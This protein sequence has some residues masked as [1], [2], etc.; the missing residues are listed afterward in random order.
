MGRGGQIGGVGLHDDALQG[1]GLGQHL[2]EGR[3][4]KRHNTADA[5][6]EAGETEELAGLVGRAPEAVEHTARQTVAPRCEHFDKLGVGRTGMDAQR[7]PP[8]RGPRYLAA[9]DGHLLLAARRIPIKVD[10]HLADGHKGM[11]RHEQPLQAVE[12]CHGVGRQLRGVEPQHGAAQAGPAAA[13]GQRR[14]ERGLVEPGQQQAHGTGSDG[15]GQ[16]VG[17]VGVELRQIEVRVRVDKLHG[18]RRQTVRF[19]SEAA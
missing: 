2:G 14:R 15:T 9:E 5:Q 18:R 4:L 3:L 12:G 19:R 10:A 6:H 13:H 7:Q 16:H 17:A 8:R 1:H 11:A